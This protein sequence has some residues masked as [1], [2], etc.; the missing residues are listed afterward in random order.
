MLDHKV[1][2]DQ[3]V[4]LVQLDLLELKVQLAPPVVMVRRDLPD[5]LDLLE[6]KVLLELLV[7]M[8]VQCLVL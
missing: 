7:L 2:L 5:L 4:I 8:V 3:K 1:I 6:L